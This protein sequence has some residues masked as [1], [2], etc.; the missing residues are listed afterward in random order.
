VI[1]TVN[2]FGFITFTS[3]AFDIDLK[4]LVLLD[5]TTGSMTTSARD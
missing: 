2:L 4:A 5:K 3:F 1:N